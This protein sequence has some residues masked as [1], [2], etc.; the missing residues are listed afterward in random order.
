M[1][2]KIN[3]NLTQE[4]INEIFKILNGQ[5]IKCIHNIYHEVCYN[6]I[7]CALENEKEDLVMIN[8]EYIEAL[9]DE[10]YDRSNFQWDELYEKACC[11]IKD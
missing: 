5:E 7:E 10:L 1:Y 4:Q 2:L 6:E 3:D 8:P 9:A 11:L